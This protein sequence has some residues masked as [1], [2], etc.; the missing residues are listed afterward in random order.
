MSLRRYPCLIFPILNQWK[1]VM[2]RAFTVS[3]RW[4][5]LSLSIFGIILENKKS[6]PTY[7]L[8]KYSRSAFLNSCTCAFF[9]YETIILF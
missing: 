3:G 8:L 9:D 6:K 5:V 2:V 4:G 7:S 1:T